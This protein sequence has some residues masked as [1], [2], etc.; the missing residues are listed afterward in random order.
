MCTWKDGCGENKI[1]EQPALI[2]YAIE[3]APSIYIVT[4]TYKEDK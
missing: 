3:K 1:W 4:E 2:S